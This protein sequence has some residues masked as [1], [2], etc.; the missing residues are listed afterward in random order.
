MWL[1]AYSGDCV[2]C[3]EAQNVFTAFVSYQDTIIHNVGHVNIRYKFYGMKKEQSM[4]AQT[5]EQRLLRLKRL[6]DKMKH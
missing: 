6:L 2:T 1:E 4:L 3:G 5:Q